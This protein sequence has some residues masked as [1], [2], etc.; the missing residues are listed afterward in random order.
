MIAHS[1][2]VLRN[3]GLHFS[4]KCPKRYV[5]WYE[6]IKLDK[7]AKIMMSFFKGCRTKLD[8]FTVYKE[9]KSAGISKLADYLVLSSRYFIFLALI[10]YNLPCRILFRKIA[11]IKDYG[12]LQKKVYELKQKLFTGSYFLTKRVKF[13]FG[14]Y[15]DHHFVQM[16][17]HPC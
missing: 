15:Q 5:L 17:S 11:C 9:M 1:S 7:N 14:D 10:F 8:F 12:N 3:I 16:F 2:S 6:F 4:L 13:S